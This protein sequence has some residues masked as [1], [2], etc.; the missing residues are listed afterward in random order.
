MAPTKIFHF[1]S[2]L[3]AALLLV[4]IQIR[5]HILAFGKAVGMFTIP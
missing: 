1:F 5:I 2:L 4:R 3:L